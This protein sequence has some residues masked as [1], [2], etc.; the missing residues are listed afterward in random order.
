MSATTRPSTENLS[1][2]KDRQKDAP[3]EVA[4]PAIAVDGETVNILIV[5]DEARNLSVLETVLVDPRY[6]LV[7]AESADEALLALVAEEFALIVLDINMPGMSGFELAELIKQRKKTAEVPIIFLTAYYSDDQH[8]LEG[9]STGAVD[10]LHKPINPTVL[11]SKV[12]VFVELYSRKRQCEL[13]AKSLLVEVA[14][15]RRA[16]ND[17]LLLNQELEHRVDVRTVELLEASAALAQSEE[18]LRLANEA[19]GTGL[20]EWNLHSN[21]VSW[22]PE[23][24]A[25]HGLVRGEFDGSLESFIG[26]VHPDDRT[27]VR[28]TILAAVNDRNVFAC[29]C[30]IVRPDGS[31]RW[32]TKKGRA[33]FDDNNQ[34]LR[35]IGTV[36]DISFRKESELHLLD[37]DRRK[38]EFLA[39]LSHELRNPLAPIRNAVQILLLA[40]LEVPNAKWATNV[41]DRQVRQMTRLVDDLLEVSRITTGKLEIRRETLELAAVIREAVETSQPL[42]EQGGHQLTVDLPPQPV[43]VNADMIRLAQV[44]SNLLNNAAKYTEA[45][46]QISIR[47]ETIETSAVVSIKDSGTGISAEMLPHIF[48]MFMQVDR[49]VPRSKGGLGIGLTLVRRLVEM[50]G[51]SIE[52]R[53]AGPGQGSAFVVRLPILAIESA[54]AERPPLAPPTPDGTSL[55]ILVVDDN[56]DGAISLGQMLQIMGHEVRVAHDGLAGIEVAEDF[57]PQVI[58]LDIGMPKLDGYDAC[59]RIRELPWG[60]STVLIALTGWG[61]EEDRRRTTAAGFDRHLVKPVDCNTLLKVLAEV[62]SPR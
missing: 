32:V 48:E 8:V 5:D 2:P 16:Q 57:R 55:R 7:R 41:I 47:L 27:R 33:F 44:F 51:G 24:Y 46:G 18:R 58:L 14:E 19:S 28:A 9:Y 34:P 13:A 22:S 50:H 42:I 4:A 1:V 21:H 20:W 37:A 12:A 59:R 36:V 3:A 25:I 49:N 43:M 35:L 15:R 11:R 40:E 38:N 26:Y 30:R 54:V 29:D 56:E 60:Q 61:Q 39:T 17:L 23:C 62:G 45:G 10:Y 53:S 6:R 52:A 31:L